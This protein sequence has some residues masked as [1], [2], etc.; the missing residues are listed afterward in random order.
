MRI[1]DQLAGDRHLDAHLDDA[2]RECR[3]DLGPHS[4][5]A[6]PYGQRECE[7]QLH[8]RMGTR[9]R[10]AERGA[11]ATKT[12]CDSCKEKRERA[13]VADPDDEA[14]RTAHVDVFGSIQGHADV[15]QVCDREQSRE[16]QRRQER[17]E[18][19]VQQVVARVDGHCPDPHN[20]Q[21]EEKA[22]ARQ[23]LSPV[24]SPPPD[25]TQNHWRSAC[26]AT[27]STQAP[28]SARRYDRCRPAPRPCGCRGA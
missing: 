5:Y 9:E 7:R 12:K 20:G 25:L 15:P 17:A 11:V 22:A 10:N 3:R 19:E 2:E 16:D 4:S 26:R 13:S 21:E 1:D 27:L 23:S 28:G 18:H 6:P 14:R 24:I 8:R